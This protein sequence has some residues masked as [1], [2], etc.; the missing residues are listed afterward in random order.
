MIKINNSLKAFEVFDDGSKFVYFFDVVEN[1]DLFEKF[2]SY[3][4]SHDDFTSIFDIE[5]SKRVYYKYRNDMLS[6][7]K[8]D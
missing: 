7:I 8:K 1:P 6:L 5:E 3:H 2:V 4:I